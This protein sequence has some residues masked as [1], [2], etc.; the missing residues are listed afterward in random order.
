MKIVQMVIDL[1]MS[2]L[3]SK[4]EAAELPKAIPA[5]STSEPK[6]EQVVQAKPSI[7]W[8]DP[9]QKVSQHFTVGEAI[10]LHS[11]NRLATLED[12]LTEDVKAQLVKTCQ[13]MDEVR[14]TIG[15]PINVNCTF[16]SVKYNQEVL[17]SLP[18][19]VHAK[20]MAIDFDC[21]SKLTIEQ[22]KEKVR[23]LLA[24]LNIRM[25]GGTTTWIHLDTKAVGPSGR[26][27]KA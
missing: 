9:S 21:N 19:D 23:P 26:E 24:K 7:D 1:I 6:Q 18:N 11:W 17:H 27:F 10:T 13:I 12:G 2:F 3:M 16:R 25:E 20:G 14:E 4:A 22:T 8:T 5:V 15:V